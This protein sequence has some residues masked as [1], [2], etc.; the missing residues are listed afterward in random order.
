MYIYYTFHYTAT[1]LTDSNLKL[2]LFSIIACIKILRYVTFFVLQLII[3]YSSYS[4]IYATTVYGGLC[5]INKTKYYCVYL[6]CL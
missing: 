2:Y 5:N 1:R 4:M 6:S 3:L